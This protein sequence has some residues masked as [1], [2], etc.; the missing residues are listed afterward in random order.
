MD[1]FEFLREAHETSVGKGFYEEER[2]V[3][4]VIAL[5]HTELSEAFEEY[6]DGH[7]VTE[8]YHVLQDGAQKPEGFPIE[9]ADVLIRIADFV[10]H[11]GIPLE[12]ALQEKLAF[13][14]TRPY[15]HGGKLL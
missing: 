4:D 8:I 11:R 3:G 13:N 7:D 5:M 2:S 15:K 6:R 9:L 10:Y 14:K 1:L 12:R